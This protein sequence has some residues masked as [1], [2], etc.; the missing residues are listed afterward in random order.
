[1]NDRCEGNEFYSMFKIAAI[2]AIIIAIII[3]GYLF[4]FTKEQY[5]SLYIIPESYQNQT[6]ND[7]IS[8]TYGVISSEEGVTDYE[9][10]IFLNN[11]LVHT[12]Q[13]Q[14]NKNEYYEKNEEL[15][16]RE[17]VTYPAKIQV[18]LNSEINT[19]EVHFWIDKNS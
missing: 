6:Q 17:N 12:E 13:F 19:E 4:I 14:L 5:S 9:S 7:R 1:M 2:V 16:L 11:E 3:T 18:I 8:F 10:K 15:L